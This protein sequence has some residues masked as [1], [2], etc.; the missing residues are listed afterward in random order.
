[1]LYENKINSLDFKILYKNK[2]E[3]Y[4]LNNSIEIIAKKV[5]CDECIANKK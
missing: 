4:K 1:M 3:K 5:S 2:C